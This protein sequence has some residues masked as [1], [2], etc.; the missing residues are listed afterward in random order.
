M[1]AKGFVAI[2]RAI[3]EHIELRKLSLTEYAALLTIMLLADKATGVWHGCSL[4]LAARFG[5]GS[6]RKQTA[7]DALRSLESAGYIRRFRIHGARGNYPIL[8]HKYEIS[9]G[10][11]KGRLTNAVATMDWQHPACC[12]ATDEGSDMAT[13]SLSDRATLSTPQ[14]CDT[15]KVSTPQ[16]QSLTSCDKVADPQKNCSAVGEIQKPIPQTTAESRPHEGTPI[17]SGPSPRVRPLP[18][19]AKV[20]SLPDGPELT[21]AE[22]QTRTHEFGAVST[23]IV[24]FEDGSRGA[25]SVEHAD[26]ACRLVWRGRTLTI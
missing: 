4:A 6:L 13:D 23:A 18:T 17:C 19:V 24:T 11:L 7:Q 20:Q 8:V 5:D 10:P 25:A 2:R 1:S 15:S 14:Q 21:A 9:I 22:W 3:L 16:N 12:A 26:G